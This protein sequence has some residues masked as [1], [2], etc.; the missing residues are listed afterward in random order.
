MLSFFPPGILLRLF[1]QGRPHP[2]RGC[3][4]TAAEESVDDP[5]RGRGQGRVRLG[6]QPARQSQPHQDGYAIVTSVLVLQV[7]VFF[8]S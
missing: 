3:D 1:L 8:S 5:S 4:E 2:S 7:S 6:V